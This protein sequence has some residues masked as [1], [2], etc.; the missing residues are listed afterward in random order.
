MS[1][2]PVPLKG[3]APSKLIPTTPAVLRL[4]IR[5]VESDGPSVDQLSAHQQRSCQ[6]LDAAKLDVAKAALSSGRAINRQFDAFYSHALE[7]ALQ[8]VLRDLRQVADKGNERR[9]SGKAGMVD[10]GNRTRGRLLVR[11]KPSARR[12]VKSRTIDSY[13]KGIIEKRT[14]ALGCV[15]EDK[16][17]IRP[18]VC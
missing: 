9:R 5:N 13:S 18:R 12:L 14:V 10:D 8:I 16:L 17:L 15:W 3:A 6:V 11:A 7:K 2:A 1:F 4:C